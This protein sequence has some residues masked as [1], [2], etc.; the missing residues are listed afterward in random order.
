MRAL[1]HFF[2]A[3]SLH[4]G[5]V[6]GTVL[7]TEETSANLVLSCPASSLTGILLIWE[8]R[9]RSLA[10][11]SGLPKFCL[12]AASPVPTTPHQRALDSLSNN[13]QVREESASES[14][15][16]PFCLLS[17]ST[18]LFFFLPFISL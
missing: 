6:P 2:I 5:V 4:V 7:S 9:L 12:L 15:A 11:H 1:I 3:H 14:L 10:C 13:T 16:H 18:H 8:E 17:N